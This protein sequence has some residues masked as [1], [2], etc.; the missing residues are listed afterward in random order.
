MFLSSKQ[1]EPHTHM[2]VLTTWTAT[3]EGAQ[4]VT[5]PQKFV[6]TPPLPQWNIGW[7]GSGLKQKKNVA[8]YEKTEN[9]SPVE[10]YNANL[11]QRGRRYRQVLFQ[12]DGK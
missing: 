8:L 2:P 1:D 12:N 9:K 10:N 5:G 3:Y 4:I 11:L 7:H 6:Y